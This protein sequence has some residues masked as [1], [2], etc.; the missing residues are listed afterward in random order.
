MARFRNMLLATTALMPLGIL[1]AVAN[2]LGPQ[3]TAGAA[4]VQGQGTS[5]VTV[6]QS[7]GKAIINW[8]TFNIGT[9]ETTQFVQPNSSSVTLNRVTG[10][11]GA[12]VLD[13][14]L[15]ANGQVFLVNPDGI[16]FGTGS[17]IN[18]GS[19]LA[20]TNDIHSADF[21]AGRYQFNIPGR[22]D[23]SIV[24]LGTITAQNGGFAALVAPGVR[25]SGTITAN[26]GTVG[27]AAGNNFSLD[28]YGDRLITLGVS[29]SIAAK[30]IDVATGQ[31]LNA[32]V[33]NDGKL[34][35]NGGRVELT[36]AAARQVVDSVINNTGIIEANSIGSRNGMIVLGAATAA[37]KPGGVPTQTIKLS[38]TILA[39]GKQKNTK[40]GTI[41]VSGENIQV[42]SATIDASGQAAGGKVLIGGDVGGGHGNAAVAAIP[43]AALESFVV[44]TASNVSV[45]SATT[46]NASAKANGSG[47]KVVIWS[48]QATTFYG[49]VKAQGGTRS[50]NGGFVETSGHQALSFDGI[51]DTGASHGKSGTLLLD[52]LNATIDVNPGNEVITTSSI[53]NALTTGNVVVSTNVVGA[54]PGNIAVVAPV[55]WFSSNTLSLNANNNIAINAAISSPNGGL[56]LNASSFGLINATASVVVG[57]FNLQS[58]NWSQVT[59][60]LPILS[61]NDFQISGGSFL[62]V[63]GGN[64]T[65]SSPYQI[66]DVYG[67][68]G[69]GS[70][71]SLL[72]SSWAL[73]NN[74]D[75]TGVAY[76]NGGAGFVP[77]GTSP[78]PFVFQSFTGTF[79]GQNHSINNLAI[80][81]SNFYLGLFALIGNGG[82]VRNVSLANAYV[83]GTGSNNSFRDVGVVAGENDGTIT[84]VSVTSSNAV[85]SSSG[86]VG[87]LVGNN[88]GSIL[89]STASTT[90]T[91]NNPTAVSVSIGGLVGSNDGIG[92][93][94]T[95]NQSSA[96]GTVSAAI[97]LAGGLVGYNIGTVSQ[98]FATGSVYGGS[99]V[100]NGQTFGSTSGGLVGQNGGLVS[101]S[102]ATGQVSSASGDAGGLVGANFS[103]GG[104]PAP[105]ILRSYAIGAVNAGDGGIAGGLT[106]VNA[107]SITQTF[108]T[109]P[110]TGGSDSLVGGLV[111]TNSLSYSLSNAPVTILQSYAIGSVTGGANSRVGGLVADNIGAT[112][113][114]SYSTG[115]VSGAGSSTVGGLV[116]LNAPGT[117]GFTGV[118]L[119]AVITNSY[120]DMQ[121]S[122]QSASAGGTGQT[123]AQLTAGLPSGF[124]STVWT[125]KLGASYPYFPWQPASTIP[126]AGATPNSQPTLPAGTPAYPT[127]QTAF[128]TPANNQTTNSTPT[129]T[130]TPVEI[131]VPATTPVTT[132]PTNQSGGANPTTNPA[133]PIDL[134]DLP[135]I[136]QDNPSSYSNGMPTTY[137]NVACVAAVYAMIATALGDKGA[138]VD[139]F[140]STS[141][142]GAVIKNLLNDPNLKYKIT[143]E[144][145]YTLGSIASS[146][147]KGSSVNSSS[148]SHESDL[149]TNYNF[150][151]SALVQAVEKPGSMVVI[152]GYIN[153]PHDSSGL[154]TH[155]MLAA[156]LDSEGNII[157]KD[158]L[159]GMTL[160]INPSNNTITDPNSVTHS[161]KAFSFDVLTYA[162]N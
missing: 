105:V 89:Q 25:N 16:L 138:K 150:N 106:A 14:T 45:D 53:E 52:P 62:R 65:S 76:W 137:M 90:V 122:G 98:S 151:L 92:T 70:S 8:Q 141:S 114:Q 107:G 83:F 124:D 33:Q 32:L 145:S 85:I 132:G 110:V 130:F 17:K 36:A 4:N 71:A 84:N 28:F 35:A 19:F 18:T 158:P 108:A 69:I 148:A 154:T 81:S 55:T 133:H 129:I 80:N 44:P 161:F 54:E 58:G 117:S 23:A 139:Q 9:G 157:V 37:T 5:T 156:G 47:G 34:K 134:A 112:I 77:I 142:G 99:S 27:L 86:S 143:G 21:M 159:S 101:D 104:L 144:K 24:N 38:G 116:A 111:G 100:N 95:I 152:N 48:D 91:A 79:D 93:F 74:V 109:G 153:A 39:A 61:A 94:G 96:T 72:S 135:V 22:P 121:S 113:S 20:T 120:W 125:I 82:V 67:L 131:S 160:T 40:G 64:G 115:S 3:V 118:T 63:I 29:D 26:L 11:L 56:T 7:T 103:P 30:V 2:P 119:P 10:N 51:V 42:T 149:A 97:G 146:D 155:T 60:N 140:Y 66:T 78:S 162:E 147:L 87:G 136:G 127:G 57:N 41:I 31:P 102:Y 126:I 50:G 123:T 6:T 49:T 73:A 1:A 128:F 12:S 75:A 88:T 46:I 68:Q 13:G 43:M 15:T 59:P